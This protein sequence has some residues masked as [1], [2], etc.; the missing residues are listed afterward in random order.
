MQGLRSWLN[1]PVVAII[2][3]GIIAAGVR[4][5]HLSYPTGL[6]FDEVY[7]AKAGC[8]YVGWSDKT[9]MVTSVDEKYW[10]SDAVGGKWDVGSWVHPPLGKWQ[11]ALGEKAFGMTPFGWRVSSAVVGTGA[12]VAL[13]GIAQLLWGSA[14]WTFIAGLLLATE[15]LNVVESRAALLDIH[16]EFWVI[17]GFLFLLLDRRWIERRTP[18]ETREDAAEDQPGPPGAG[19]YVGEHVPRSVR[20][21]SPIWR[22]WRFAA[23]IGFALAASVKWSGLTALLAAGI[24]TLM[25]E[26]TRRHRGTTGWG[27][28]F[29]RAFARESFGITL[30]FLVVPVIVYLAVYIPWFNHFGWSLKDWWANQQAMWHYLANLKA[31]ALDAATKTYTPTHPYYSPAWTWLI[32]RRPVSYW[33]KDGLNGAIANIVAIGNPAIFWGSILA[34]PFTAWCWRRTRDWRAGFILLAVLVQWLPWFKVTRPQFFFYVLPMTPFMVL[35]CVY[36]VRFLH[37]ASTV[38]TAPGVGEPGVV[39]PIEAA[40]HPFRPIAWIFVV[41]AVGLFVW[42]WPVLTGST[43]S[44]EAW[45]MRIWADVWI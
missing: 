42:F 20:I 28:A 7:Y 10:R 37:L 39:E 9:C 40:R 1:R 30:A 32:M 31:T 24:L 17:M 29:G 15:S 33:T 45:R 16:L 25:W 21:P 27:R 36:T 44:R 26:T 38:E 8:I 2:A 23:G 13:A 5:A 34:L 19:R 14:L 3:A 6:V 43:L 41:L 22:P 35:A 18:G 4:F 12:V 11:I